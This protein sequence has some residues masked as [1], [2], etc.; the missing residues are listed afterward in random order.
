MHTGHKV[1]CTHKV[2]AQISFMFAFLCFGIEEKDEAVSCTTSSQQFCLPVKSGVCQSLRFLNP[3]GPV[4]HGEAVEMKR[5][6]WEGGRRG[7]AAGSVDALRSL[8]A[9]H[10]KQPP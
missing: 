1:V 6:K 3:A 7:E 5:G 2:F 9:A 10:G 4:G 8:T